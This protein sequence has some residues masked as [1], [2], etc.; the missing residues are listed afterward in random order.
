MRGSAHDDRYAMDGDV[1]VTT[2][3]HH[4]GILG[5]ISTG[6]P[7]LLRVALKPA[8]SI[9]QPLDT[10]TTDGEATTVTT[11]GRH[12]PCL[13]PRFVPVAEAMVALVLADHHLRQRAIA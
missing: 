9:P 12:D 11:K 4:G 6:M 13:V 7:L 3:N 2:T 1:V 5:G 10:V 8:S